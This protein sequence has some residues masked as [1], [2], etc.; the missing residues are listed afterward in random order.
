M[1]HG[2]FDQ[3]TLAPHPGHVML[4]RRI[5]KHLKL[6]AN[7]VRRKRQPQPGH[8]LFQMLMRTS[9]ANDADQ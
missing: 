9:S 1:H 7:S 8:D 2:R 5:P 6:R 4:L 3:M